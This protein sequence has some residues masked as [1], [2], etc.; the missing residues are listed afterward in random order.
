MKNIINFALYIK[1][2]KMSKMSSLIEPS[3]KQV[4]EAEAYLANGVD[5]D[6]DNKLGYFYIDVS[7]KYSVYYT[8]WRFRPSTS[9]YVKPTQFI[10]NL[11]TDFQ[12]AIEKA[13]K[14]AGRVPIIIDR[15]GTQAGLFKAAKAEIVTFGKYRGKTLGDIFT[16]DPQYI[17]WMYKND[18]HQSEE[19]SERLKYYHE[20][21]METVR[22]KN[23]E[24]SKSVFVGNIGDTIKIVSADVYGYEAK[25]SQF[26]DSILHE[27]KL[28]DENG[29]KYKTYNI[30]KPVNNGDTVNLTAKVKDHKE[31][32][33]VK[34]TIIYY[35][36]DVK[37]L[38]EDTAKYNL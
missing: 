37:V 29:N 36:K 9:V 34:F 28:V 11:S 27:C 22:K 17:E 19:R 4:E 6:W 5:P 26:N 16:E 33:G 38:A 3:D 8:F 30:G 15:Y 14:A 12:K 13:K 21:Y 10:T 23:L 20:I 1:E 31:L 35:C 32:L 24:E 25:P 18:K 7:G 2:N